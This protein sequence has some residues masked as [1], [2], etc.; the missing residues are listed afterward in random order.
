VA[1]DDYQWSRVERKLVVACGDQI[2]RADGGSAVFGDAR[3]LFDA[4]KSILKEG[5]ELL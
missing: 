3:T 4:G 1:K 5:P 2:P